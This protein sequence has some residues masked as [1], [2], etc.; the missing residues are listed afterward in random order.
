[1]DAFKVS[2]G[3][4]GIF[5][6]VL[7]KPLALV[8]VLVLLGLM[9]RLLPLIGDPLHQDEALY[10]YW[11]RLVQ[12]GR[13]PWLATVPVDKPPLVLYLIAAS[14]AVLGASRYAVRM[15]GLAASLLSI[16]LIYALAHRLYANRTTALVAAAIM[17]LTPYPVLFGATAFTDS[18]LVACW[19]AACCTV[20]SGRWG[21]A[22][23]FMGLSIASK[24]QAILLAPLV[25]ALGMARWSLRTRREELW[26]PVA[27]FVLGLV[28]LTGSLIIWDQIRIA[29]GAATG[30]WSQ[31]VD[32][33]GG[34]RLIL[35]PELAPRLRDWL[36]LGGY[37][38]A[39]PWLT[40][41]S[42]LG[43]GVLLWSNLLRRSQSRAVLADLTLIVFAIFY[44]FFHWLVAF[45][46][47][48][49][50]LLPMV[51]LVG[52]LLGRV[53]VRAFAAVESIKLGFCAARWNPR[54]AFSAVFAL[55][56]LAGAVMAAGGH[57][58]VGGDHGAYDGLEQAV[59]YLRAL[60]IGAVL[61]DRWLTWHYDFYLFDAYLYRAGFPSPAWLATDARAFHSKSPRYVVLPSW[62]SSARLARE[63]AQVDLLMSPVFETHRR[64]GT[65]SF[66]VYEIGA[67]DSRG[68]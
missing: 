35:S 60:P 17:A 66:V 56:L 63:L 34:L 36:S 6:A 62:E 45:P 53:I 11:G 4:L 31:G 24:Q 29:A 18:V 58:P 8:V 43:I 12:T 65:S 21:W 37:L 5:A 59:A 55:L 44:L 14:Q 33:F 13:D 68:R 46:I 1:V 7:K 10:G 2:G 39:W 67:R 32:S 50:Y 27:R 3:G 23:I 30:F 54:L 22:G 48:D 25:F 57:F 38:L 20:L 19:L 9:L 40:I 15:P 42:L 28:L 26:V 51:P 41:L 49:R 64:N 47:W 52:L 16:S 61:Y